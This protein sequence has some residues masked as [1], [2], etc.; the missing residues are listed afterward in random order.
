M[1]LSPPAARRELRH[2]RQIRVRGYEREDGLIDVEAE[3]LDTRPYDVPLSDRPIPAGSPLH[4]MKARLTVNLQMEI[5]A[6]EAITIAG[7]YNVCPGSAATFGKL[8]GMTIKSGFLKAANE[9]MGG[10]AGCTHIREF[11]QQMATV[12][13]QATFRRR[14]AD[15]PEIFTTPNARQLNSCFA[16]STTGERVK[17]KWPQFYEGEK[18]GG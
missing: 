18:V 15:T 5:L 9:V 16:Y 8:V 10:G 14:W 17:A 2:D 6:A 13:H 4:Q 1:D 12:A 3:L 7:P 11:L